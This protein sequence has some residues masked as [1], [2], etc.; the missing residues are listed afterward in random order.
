[1]RGE[2]R[3]QVKEKN[4]TQR[5]LK[6]YLKSKS[7]QRIFI[8][9]IT[10]IIAFVVVENGA[11]PTKYKLTLGE[12]SPYDI[13]APRDIENRLKAEELAEAAAKAVPSVMIRLDNVAIDI[14]NLTDDFFSTVEEARKG[15]EKS[16]QDQNITKKD[17]DYDK[18]LELE[19]AIGAD[20]LS[21]NLLQFRVPL[22]GEQIKYLIARISDEDLAKF[23]KIT[24]DAVSE[25]MKEEI[26][27]ANLAE[28]V[29]E[30]QNSYQES[31]ISQEIRNIGSLF[32]KAVLQPNSTEDIQLTN[33]KKEA[34][35]E[36]ALENKQI[37]SEGTRILSF[38]DT[39][40]EDK[41][42]VLKELNLLESGRFDYAFALGILLVVLMLAF[43]LVLYMNHFSRKML[44]N[45]N[46]I[47]LLCV[48]ILMT[49]VIARI[50]CIYTP[51]LIP[52]FIAPML[53][54]ILLDLRLAILVNIL[55]TV[56]ISFI[57][58]GEMSLTY[59]SVI[60]GTL[61]AFIVSRANQR[62]KLSASGLI[63]AGTNVLVIV[64][65]GLLNKNTLANI[66][67]DSGLVALNGVLSMIFT[68]GILPFFEST[69]N[70]ITPLKLLELANPN[71]QLIKRL[72]MEAPGTYHH[73]LMVGNL[74]EVATEAIEGNAL[75]ARVGAYYH[76]IGKLKR[77]NFFKENQLTDN[78]HDRM[79]PNLST[80]VITSH[81]ADGV[82]IAERYKIPMAIKEIISQHHGTTL[83]AYF[84]YK[85]KKGDKGDT[86]KQEDF[87]YQGP[88][89]SSKEAAVVM[90]ADSVEAA[91]RSMVD[92]TEGKIEGLIRKIIKDKLD[93]GQLDLCDLT[94]RDLDMIA[95][96]FLRVFGGFFH[97]REAYPEIKIKK[98]PVEDPKMEE[99]GNIIELPK[100]IPE[101][102]K[103]SASQEKEKMYYENF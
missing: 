64:C 88:R 63:V 16:L 4:N 1:M 59:I 18:K 6:T 23:K 14:L 68:I 55:L 73:S 28:K 31:D 46:D 94:L 98:L 86:V 90:L 34:A 60:S 65:M 42:E 13:T 52:I 21:E 72:L 24:K 75:L 37:I 102:V 76:D 58:K 84:Y 54:S 71:Q 101:S 25:V 89:P 8:G 95:R 62:S 11:S 22:S 47:L 36:S 93:D 9:I 12:R 85:A 29:N 44:Q 81:T 43:I 57:T 3:L 87:R 70:I 67:N 66:A 56:C 41:L 74:A 30:V 69:F 91:V 77:P 15:V 20:R 39:V 10:V 100:Q 35:Y 61:S 26:T 19:Q 51:L 32:V 53:I 5:Y 82:E 96:A 45:R 83:V 49:L 99:P 103:I 48:I 17:T 2:K 92:K 50:L 27:E 7:F 78:P 80:L 38:G 40:T 97:A 79:T 33:E